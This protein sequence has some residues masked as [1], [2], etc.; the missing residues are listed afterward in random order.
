MGARHDSLQTLVPQKV[1]GQVEPFDVGLFDPG[2]AEVETAV[3]HA[4][5]LCM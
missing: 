5:R 3:S 4:S 2:D 1:G